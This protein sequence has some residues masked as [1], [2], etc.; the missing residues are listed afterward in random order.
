LPLHE[1]LRV[2]EKKKENE[3]LITLGNVKTFKYKKC[4]KVHV[5]DINQ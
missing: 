2:K 1:I 3:A 5:A 4:G